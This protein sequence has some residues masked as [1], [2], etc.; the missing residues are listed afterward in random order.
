MDLMI[1]LR[2]T[3]LCYICIKHQISV[4]KKA[5]S[6]PN[7]LFENVHIIYQCLS[8]VTLGE[9]KHV[10]QTENIRDKSN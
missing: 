2:K 5:V 10:K 4:C 3:T 8:A 7:V 1:D 6:N 9:I